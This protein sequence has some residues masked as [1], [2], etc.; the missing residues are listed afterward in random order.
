[1]V[2]NR[3]RIHPYVRD[4]IFMAINEYGDPDEQD[5]DDDE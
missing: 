3:L 1:M 5:R 4:V 2:S